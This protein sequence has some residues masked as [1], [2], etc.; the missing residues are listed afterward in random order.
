ME[1]IE[2]YFAV[3][4]HDDEPNAALKRALTTARLIFAKVAGSPMV[5]RP[6]AY[7]EIAAAAHGEGWKAFAGALTPDHIVYAGPA[8]LAFDAD[9]NRDEFRAKLAVF[10]DRYDALPKIIVIR[11][12]G[13][14]IAAATEAHA[15]AAEELAASALQTSALADGSV[16]FMARRDVDFIVHWEVEQ[17]RQKQMPGAGMPQPGNSKS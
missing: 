4:D 17:F 14:L 13:V 2:R 5:V 15:R 16:K 11:N 10:R 6:T 3:A 7:R 1:R 12:A 9:V 8:A